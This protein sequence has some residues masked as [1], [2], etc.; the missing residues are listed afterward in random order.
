MIIGR[1]MKLSF[2][3]LAFLFSLS[4]ISLLIASK[5]EAEGWGWVTPISEGGYFGCGSNSR[6]YAKTISYTTTNSTVNA[7]NITVRIRNISNGALVTT[8]T[9]SV[10]TNA[11]NCFNLFT[12]Y[13]EITVAGGNGW[14]GLYMYATDVDAGHANDVISL[15]IYVVPTSRAHSIDAY[16]PTGGWFKT[17]NVTLR[18]NVTTISPT[19]GATCSR[20]I[21]WYWDGG[22][23]NEGATACGTGNFSKTFSFAEG[24]HTW[25]AQSRDNACLPGCFGKLSGLASDGN[26][27]GWQTFYVDVTDPS[28]SATHSPLNPFSTQDVTITASTTD[29]SSGQKAWSAPSSRARSTRLAIKSVTITTPP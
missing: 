18:A 17:N 7:G 12:Q 20:A 28:V 23:R 19:Y 22:F 9:G 2:Y 4:V 21:L 13:F 25:T 24:S 27:L 26:N 15:R 11:Y 14:K 10:A 1:A 29:S 8:L 6:I 16:S 5:V 3:T